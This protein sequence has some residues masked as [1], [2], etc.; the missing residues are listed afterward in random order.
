MHRACAQRPAHRG[1]TI[2]LCSLG[3]L[4]AAPTLTSHTRREEARKTERRWFSELFFGGS[5]SRQRIL[6]CAVVLHRVRRDVVARSTMVGRAQAAATCEQPSSRAASR[7]G[8]AAHRTCSLNPQSSQSP[9]FKRD[10]NISSKKT[11]VDTGFDTV[12]ATG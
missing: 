6:S 5:S 10:I 2:F 1:L 7:R 9:T 4:C 8:V 3:A 11:N 12:I